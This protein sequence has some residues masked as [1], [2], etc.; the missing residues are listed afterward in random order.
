MFRRNSLTLLLAAAL[1]VGVAFADGSSGQKDKQKDKEK[2]K[3][4]TKHK[5][6]QEGVW[7]EENPNFFALHV[8]EG[9]YLGVYLEEVTG[10]RAKELGLK[11]ERGA[12]IMKVV[13]DSPAQKAGLK[14]NDVIVSFNGRRV[15]SVRELQRLMSETPADRNIS[16][17]V[18]RGGSQQTLSAALSKHSPRFRFMPNQMEELHR[19]D[20]ELRREQTEREREMT[21]REREMAREWAEKLHKDQQDFGNFNFTVPRFFGNLRGSRLGISV[22]TMSDQLAE[23]FGVKGNQGVLVTEVSENGPAQKAG[24]KAGDVI[25]S[26]D[27]TKIDGVS[28]LLNAITQKESG[29]VTLTIIRNRTEQTIP[30]TLEKRETRPEPRRR[31]ATISQNFSV[32]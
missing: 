29:Q 22:E 1:G 7:I 15:D 11:E 3:A 20:S 8:G 21:E 13:E 17:E 14:E 32:V 30:V 31:G 9:S 24:L 23:Y 10:E 16:I 12:V 19:L 18:I 5:D 25:T 27:G 28:G 2:E 6:K 26:V 4:E